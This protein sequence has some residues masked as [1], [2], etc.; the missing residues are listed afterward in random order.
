MCKVCYK[1]TSIASIYAFI[2]IAGNIFMHLTWR[3]R[4]FLEYFFEKFQ[5]FCYRQNRQLFFYKGTVS[6]NTLKTQ[7]LKEIYF[8]QFL[9]VVAFGNTSA[10]KRNAQ[11]QWL[12]KTLELLQEISFECLLIN[13]YKYKGDFQNAL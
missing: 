12:K 3:V 7:V 9:R 13:F 1:I 10:N 6:Y 2:V 4:C 8:S 5:D 11:I